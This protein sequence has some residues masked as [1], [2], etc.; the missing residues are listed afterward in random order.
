MT[1]RAAALVLFLLLAVLPTVQAAPPASWDDSAPEDLEVS[2]VTALPGHRDPSAWYGHSGILVED[3][4]RNESA[5]YGYILDQV[6]SAWRAVKTGVGDSQFRLVAI[7]LEEVLADYAQQGREVQTLRLRLAPDAAMALATSLAGTAETGAWTPYDSIRDNCSTR[8]RDH[9]DVA[10]GGALRNATSNVRPGDPTLREATRDYLD[11]APLAATGMRF[12]LAAEGDRPLSAWERMFLPLELDAALDSLP[13]P[14]VEGEGARTLG[15]ERTVILAPEDPFTPAEPFRPAP[16]LALIGLLAGALIGGA[17]WAWRASPRTG[18]ALALA[19]SALGLLLAPVAALLLVL[20]SGD[21]GIHFA[22]NE[23]V[24]VVPPTVFAYPV[25]GVLALL[26]R[27]RAWTRLR[28]VATATAV[29]GLLALLLKPLPVFEQA[30]ANALALFV[31]LHL[32][33]AAAAWAVVQGRSEAGTDGASE[34]D[35]DPLRTA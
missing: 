16:A 24:L 19:F 1:G 26:R 12:F 25:L 22:Y 27:P 18:D 31:P 23:N 33:L 30:N 11:H 35:G 32:G 15:G 9:V 14:D 7:P 29:L 10:L 3:P 34:G 28:G 5:Y 13:L 2:L 17:A 20:W 4:A 8:L 21:F 6:G